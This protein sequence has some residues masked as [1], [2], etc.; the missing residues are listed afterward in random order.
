M[1]H[2]SKK[3]VNIRVNTDLTLNVSAPKWVV[4]SELEKILSQKSTW[5]LTNIEKQRKSQKE[6]KINIFKNHHV[7]WLKGKK[8]RFFYRQAEENAIE[9]LE[10]QI[11]VYSKK[12]D[13]IDYSKK[14]FMDWLREEA[15]KEFYKTL[16][17]YRNRMVKKYRIPEFSLQIR[18]MKTRWGTCTPGKKKITLNLN[19]MYVPQEY[20]E[21]VALHELAHFVEIYHNAQFYAVLA[22]YMPDWKDRQT[23]LNKEY[24]QIVR[25]ELEQ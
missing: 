4:K 14:I 22:S 9:I 3:N 19:L 11:V 24:S 18:S 10:E 25:K 2:N 15:Y 21:Y 23:A 20:M 17:Y 13:D 1:N 6:K 8:Y 5:I 12:A 16:C 7:I